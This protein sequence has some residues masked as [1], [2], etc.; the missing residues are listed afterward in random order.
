[1]KPS[2]TTTEEVRTFAAMAFDRSVYSYS[3]GSGFRILELFRMS[4]NK[5]FSRAHRRANVKTIM[6]KMR[7]WGEE[8]WDFSFVVLWVRVFFPEVEKA[9]EDSTAYDETLGVPDNLL[10]RLSR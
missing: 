10:P 7:R 3:S 1:M 2:F 8:P 5:L 6:E 4:P 9:F